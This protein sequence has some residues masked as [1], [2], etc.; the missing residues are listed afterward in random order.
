[1]SNPAVRDKIRLILV[2]VYLT[3]T[4]TSDVLFGAECTGSDALSFLN[5]NNGN[6]ELSCIRSWYLQD[7]DVHVN[8][9]IRK[10]ET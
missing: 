2:R 4:R 8:I 3:K 7:V 9:M 1:M 5:S 6:F 10:R